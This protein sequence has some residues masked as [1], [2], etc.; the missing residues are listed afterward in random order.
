MIQQIP[1]RVPAPT[2]PLSYIQEPFWVYEQLRGDSFPYLAPFYPWI[3]GPLDIAAL[4]GALNDVIRGQEVLRSVIE[5]IDGEPVQR[6]LPFTPISLEVEDFSNQPN[7]EAAVMAEGQRAVRAPL[8]LRCGMVGSVRLLRAT[9]Q[10]HLLVMPIHHAAFDASSHGV[11]KQQLFKTFEARIA[12]RT[13]VVPDPPIQYADFAT[14]QREHMSDE[15]NPDL[16]YWVQRLEGAPLI[17]ELP[18]DRPRLP[19][20]SGRRGSLRSIVPAEVDEAVKALSLIEDA[21]RF[22]IYF[23]VFNVLLTRYTGVRD[24]VVEL[25]VSGRT[26]PETHQTVGPFINMVLLRTQVPR[27]ITFREL[28]RHVRDGVRRDLEHSE[29]PLALL[30]RRLDVQ[31]DASP[32]SVFRVGFNW[33]PQYSPEEHFGGVH[34]Y[35]RRD[36]DSLVTLQDVNMMLSKTTLG[37]QCMIDYDAHLYDEARIEELM[38]QWLSLVVQALDNPDREVDAYSLVTERTKMILPDPASGQPPDPTAEVTGADGG[39]A[40]LLAHAFAFAEAGAVNGH[41]DSAQLFVHNPAKSL[42]GVGEL[43][44]IVVRSSR[45]ARAQLGADAAALGRFEINPATGDPGDRVYLTGTLGRFAPDASVVV[46]RRAE[47]DEFDR[48]LTADERR[49]VVDTFND[50]QAAYPHDR[51]A[52]ELIFEQAARNPDAPALFF[53]S[54]TVTYGE[55][56]D[57]AMALAVRLRAVGVGP[58]Q[59]VAIYMENPLSGVVALMG[60]MAAG[61][62]YVSLDASQPV[63]RLAAMLEDCRPVAIVTTPTVVAN[64]PAGHGASVVFIEDDAGIE[65]AGPGGVGIEVTPDDLAYVLYTSGSTGAPKGVMVTHRNLVSS[66]WA[67]VVTYGDP[68]DRALL[69]HSLAFDASFAILHWALFTGGSVRLLDDEL[70]RDAAR[71]PA[72]FAAHGITHVAAIPAFWGHLLDE[73]RPGELNSVRCV[74]VGA[75]T[76]TV[77]TIERHATLLPECRIF[78]EY[79]PTETT[80]WSTVWKYTPEALTTPVGKRTNIPIGKP[81]PNT[82]AYVLD[83]NLSPLPVGVPGELFLG[84]DGVTRGYL[85]HDDLTAERF[86]PNPFNGDSGSRLYRTGDKARWL[87][88][89]NLEFLG[90]ID[91]QVKIRGYRVELGEIEAALR[92]HES[93]RDVAAQPWSSDGSGTRLVAYVVGDTLPS[94]VDLREHCMALLPDYMVPAAFVQLSALPVNRNGKLDRHALPAPGAQNFAI[95]PYVAPRDELERSLAAI[96]S[97]V[98]SVSRVGIDDD[99]FALGGDSLLALRLFARVHRALG[100]ELPIAALFKAPTIAGLAAM[101]RSDAQQQEHGA[102]VAVQ[103]H[104]DRPNL[105]LVPGA[106]GNAFEFRLLSQHLGD[107]QPLYSLQAEGTDGDGR[108]HTFKTIEAMAAV[109]LETMQR[110]QANGPYYISGFSMGCAV[111]F[112]MARQLADKGGTGNLVLIDPYYSEWNE[113]LLRGEILAYRSDWWKRSRRLQVVPWTILRT[114]DRV[115]SLRRLLVCWA[116]LALGRR[117]PIPLRKFYLDRESRQLRKRYRPLPYHG[118]I[119]L[120]ATDQGSD[121]ASGWTDLALG[122]VEVH[123]IPGDHSNLLEEP[124]VSGVAA[125]LRATIDRT[126]KA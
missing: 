31:R 54:T 12:G 101:L 109:Y 107:D 103:P 41:H 19:T 30:T 49:L 61:G 79:G 27:G 1:R 80:V 15:G 65:D 4:E 82:R 88:D 26:R 28:V 119:T 91:G 32:T 97:E 67:R 33:V 43:G 24:L 47:P 102:L 84:G 20:F 124:Y 8:D 92:R 87:P 105:F 2:A 99:F 38:E 94:P 120:L 113:V 64:L 35:D 123:P 83:K 69:L 95:R 50:T 17:V 85:N 112:E 11:F 68:V 3:E 36:I 58:G 51:C 74:L 52:H 16:D 23:A 89:G 77:A 81:I 56:R 29:L 126:S 59:I 10:L 108:R 25:P 121:P 71:L 34:F 111:A 86:V 18:A 66:T 55:L 42:A 62:A 39:A 78:N 106:G 13:P 57:Q 125:Q 115:R 63:E 9:P 117:I 104:G 48:E 72:L 44:E 53:D 37:L 45:F 14:W 116:Y 114:R 46:D 60:I 70:R 22:H 90:R 6:V 96:W 73:A 110:K 76:C 100:Q 5:V 122:G 98:L 93:I 40:E 21:T 7:P 118:R 75:D